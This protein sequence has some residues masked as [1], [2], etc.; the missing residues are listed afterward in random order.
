VLHGRYI[1]A[2]QVA[3]STPMPSPANPT[4]NRTTPRVTRALLERRARAL[5]RHLPAAIEGDGIGVHQARVASRRLR[6]AVPVLAQDIKTGKAKKAERKI[7]RLTKAL[8]AVRELD[9]TLTVLDELAAGDTLP[10]LGL[11]EV[12]THVVE[13]RELRRA[14]ML[15][16]LDKVKID[17]MDRRLAS[18]AEALQVAETEHWRDAL[19]ARLSKRAKALSSAVA[20]AGQMYNPE[21]LHQVRIAIKKLRYGLEV[22]AE[23][24]VR[25]ATPVVNRLKRTQDTLGRLHDLQVLESHVAAVQARPAE[26][27]LPEDSLPA[28]ARALENECRYLHGRYITSVP[29]LAAATEATKLVVAQLI[30][31]AAGRRHLKM[32]LPARSRRR[33]VTAAPAVA[34]GKR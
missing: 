14:T 26:R 5:K 18:V 11:E 6:E 23:G 4:M 16:R 8:G 10:R 9:V 34:A 29:A 24:A 31:P 22:A 27:A 20:E 25:A 2:Q 33:P 15:R 21:R 1:L 19:A 13:E 30:K 28:I 12:R 32:A 17:K 3:Y 7:R